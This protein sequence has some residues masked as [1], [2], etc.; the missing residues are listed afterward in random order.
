MGREGEAGRNAA[1]E[2]KR[3]KE[4][5]ALYSR[6]KINLLTKKMQWEKCTGL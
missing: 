4:S 1:R 2:N 5:A 3:K 6:K